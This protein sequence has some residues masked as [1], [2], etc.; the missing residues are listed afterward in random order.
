MLLNGAK[1]FRIPNLKSTSEIKTNHA[2]FAKKLAEVTR[3]PEAPITAFVDRAYERH[4]SIIDK[5]AYWANDDYTM[6]S[7]LISTVTGN[8]EGGSIVEQSIDLTKDE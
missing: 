5:V 1:G 6:S 2:M 4:M 7:N 8:Q 3:I